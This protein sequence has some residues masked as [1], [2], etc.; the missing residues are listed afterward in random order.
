MTL[1]PRNGKFG[2]KVWDRGQKRYRWLG[3]FDTEAE[4]LRAER[5]ANLQPGK[6]APTVEQW[7]RIWLSDYARPAPATRLVYR[8][9]VKVITEAVGEVRLD[10][11]DRPAARR[12][13][14]GWPRNTSAV[15]RTMWEDAKRDGVCR[16][17]PWANLRLQQ[18]RGRRDIVALTESDVIELANVAERVHKDYGLEA[19]AIVL[20]LAYV[21]IRPGELCAL[22]WADVDV[23]D[24]E[25]HVRRSLDATGSEKLP[26]NGKMRTVTIPPQA[27]RS[28]ESVPRNLGD[29][30]VFHSVTGR[31]L[32]KANLWYL[33]KPIAVAWET[34]GH[35]HIDLYELRHA[36]ATMLLERGATHGDVAVQL[37]HEDGGALVLERYGHPDK[38]RARDRLKMAYAGE[39]RSEKRERVRRTGA[40]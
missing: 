31:R 11:V 12:L 16:E 13:A 35:D 30:Y 34:L 20:V 9:A 5:D 26:K 14:N 18:S 24:R 39:E 6:D 19:R 4:A 1:V 22:K 10:E 40:A 17:N 3:S 15:A 33:W 28:L 21:A 32:T 23:A 27:L 37:G 36:A 2:V 7:G 38:S 25:M 8:Q 29:D